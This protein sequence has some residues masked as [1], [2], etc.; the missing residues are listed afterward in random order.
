MVLTR[1]VPSPLVIMIIGLVLQESGFVKG[2]GA[3]PESAL[4][5]HW[6]DGFFATRRAAG[7]EL[8]ASTNLS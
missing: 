5:A 3:Q 4:G 6:P 1:K 8:F 2:S 7:S